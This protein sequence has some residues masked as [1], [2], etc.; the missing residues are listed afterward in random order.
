MHPIRFALGAALALTACGEARIPTTAIAAGT[1]TVAFPGQPRASANTVRSRHGRLTEHRHTL[2]LQTGTYD[3]TWWEFPG[4][5]DTSSS[6]DSMF[7]QMRDL[8]VERT[9]GTVSVDQPWSV[10]GA[11]GREVRIE[12]AQGYW[13]AMRMVVIGSTYYQLAFTGPLAELDG[14]NA[15]A[16]FDSLQP[17]TAA[18]R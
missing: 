3:L 11:T 10:H 13:R 12:A 7:D 17:A 1:H 15:K 18:P 4:S 8:Q 2:E 6:A 16:F 14:A 5:V 9:Q